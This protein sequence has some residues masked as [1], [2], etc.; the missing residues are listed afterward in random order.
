MKYTHT[1]AMHLLASGALSVR[2]AIL[3]T[4]HWFPGPRLSLA[5]F[6]TVPQT[7]ALRHLNAMEQEGL[8]KSSRNRVRR[9]ITDT[10]LTESGKAE[11]ERML[12]VLKWQ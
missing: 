5:A 6:T 4:I 2:A 10:T 12:E 3:L 1:E 9:H 11:V 8:L 7:T